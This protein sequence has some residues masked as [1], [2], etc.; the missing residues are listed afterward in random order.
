MV[1][2]GG[3][4]MNIQENTRIVKETYN[5]IAEFFA[6][7]LEVQNSSK[8]EVAFMDSF[9]SHLSPNSTV[10]D[11]GCG[12]GKHGRYCASRGHRVTGYDISEEMIK[13]AKKYNDQYK[14]EFLCVA[15]MC[16]I[17]TDKM[18]DG[19]VAMYSLIHLTTEQL[20]LSFNNLAKNLKPNAKLVLSVLVGDGERF[21]P[22]GLKPD[23]Q[24]FFKYYQ[25]DELVNLIADL[26]FCVDEVK[27]WKDED[28]ITASNTDIDYGVIGLIG[29]WRGLEH[30]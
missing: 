4:D 3:N 23:M 27:L 9:L 19:I 12:V 22:E 20:I 28:E 7:M 14:M 16:D 1:L 17:K 21:V 18:F 15:D 6:P 2:V 5:A 13:R 24:Q 29:T 11:L 30:E 8:V 10:I 25:K 26:G